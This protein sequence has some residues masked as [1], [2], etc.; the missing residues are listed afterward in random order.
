MTFDEKFGELGLEE[1]E[2]MV[3]VT[4]NL[5]FFYTICCNIIFDTVIYNMSLSYS[6]ENELFKQWGKPPRP[7]MFTGLF[8]GVGDANNE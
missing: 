2:S 1:E 7:S 5:R 6:P 3:T 4:D 8:W